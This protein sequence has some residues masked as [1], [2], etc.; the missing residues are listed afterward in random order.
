MNLRWLI[1][2]SLAISIAACDNGPL[3]PTSTL[4]GT[5]GGT[6]PGYTM[7][8]TLTQQDTIVTGGAV[9]SGV[10]GSQGFDVI[11]TIVARQ[12]FLTLSATNFMPFTFSGTLSTTEAVME[13]KLDGSGFNKL[14]I[15]LKKR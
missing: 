7:S 15:T 13:G 5:W 11:G 14:A 1:A 2:A 3:G 4:D 8:L 12:F 9:L 10:G 6:T